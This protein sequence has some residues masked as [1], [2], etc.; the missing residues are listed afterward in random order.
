M[1]YWNAVVKQIGGQD[2]WL[3]SARARCYERTRDQG[4]LGSLAIRYSRTPGRIFLMYI[5][6][7]SY[8]GLLRYLD[9]SCDYLGRLVDCRPD[10]QVDS[11]ASDQVDQRV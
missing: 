6:I 1:L 9:K 3:L 10:D 8:K 5:P 4:T 7:G 11:V 2:I